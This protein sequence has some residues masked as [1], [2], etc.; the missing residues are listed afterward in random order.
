MKETGR[1]TQH[2]F[3]VNF[4]G[5]FFTVG[6]SLLQIDEGLRENSWEAIGNCR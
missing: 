5:F 6:K 3:P 4:L 2:C 1:S